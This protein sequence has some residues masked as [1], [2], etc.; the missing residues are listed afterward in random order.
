MFRSLC[1]GSCSAQSMLVRGS[2]HCE[3]VR[4]ITGSV[5]INVTT[6]LTTGA[7]P[8]VSGGVMIRDLAKVF[9]CLPL[10]EMYESLRMI[11]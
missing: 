1:T 9:D 6:K 4:A 2:L 5:N 10:I 8:E 3:R 11:D 7:L